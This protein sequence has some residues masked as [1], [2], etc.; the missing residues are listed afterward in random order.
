MASLAASVAARAASLSR[1]GCH[2]RRRGMPRAAGT[3]ALRDASGVICL[4]VAFH[5]CV[6]LPSPLAVF[7]SGQFLRARSSPPSGNCAAMHATVRVSRCSA[8]VLAAAQHSCLPAKPSRRR[9]FGCSPTS[10]LADSPGKKPAGSGGASG[11]TSSSTFGSSTPPHSTCLLQTC[12][13]WFRRAAPRL[14][15]TDL[16]SR[17]WRSNS[18]ASASPGWAAAASSSCSSHATHLM[19]RPPWPSS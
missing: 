16:S 13:T 8:R 14:L 7:R 2:D 12:T 9:A 11:G 5:A 15:A 10:P 4:L 1:A 6:S 18:A 19:W 3:F 17:Q